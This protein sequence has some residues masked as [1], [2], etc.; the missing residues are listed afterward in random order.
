M[1][2]GENFLL[3]FARVT[4]S[5]LLSAHLVYFWWNLLS[6]YEIASLRENGNNFIYLEDEIHSVYSIDIPP[7]SP[8]EETEIKVSRCGD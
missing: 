4:I 1:V 8:T 7:S 2:D 6:R 3:G 5:P